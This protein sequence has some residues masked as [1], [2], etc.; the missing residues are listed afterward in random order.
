MTNITGVNL[1]I[2]SMVKKSGSVVLPKTVKQKS[3]KAQ[4]AVL[5]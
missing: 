1:I 4:M 5:T 2:R 3:W